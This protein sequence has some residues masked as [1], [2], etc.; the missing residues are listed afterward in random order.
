MR[1]C[2]CVCVYVGVREGKHG[3]RGAWFGLVQS[4]SLWLE[5]N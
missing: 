3:A 2:V 4:S 5:V 1:V